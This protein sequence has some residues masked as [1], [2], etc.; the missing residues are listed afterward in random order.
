MRDLARRVWHDGWTALVL[1][2]GLVVTA[3]VGIVIDA[4]SMPLGWRIA[5][6]VSGLAVAV[7]GASRLG[8]LGP[9]AAANHAPAPS[10]GGRRLEVGLLLLVVLVAFVLGSLQ[11]G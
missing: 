11:S 7:R 2:L 6:I 9:E 10:R 4:G 1:G 8:W 3:V 5:S